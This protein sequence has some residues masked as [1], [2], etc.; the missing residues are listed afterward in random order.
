MIFFSI[1]I[2][3]LLLLHDFSANISKYHV[4]KKKCKLLW[5][6]SIINRLKCDLIY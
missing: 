6:M 4:L 2:I 3:I 5:F 1:I